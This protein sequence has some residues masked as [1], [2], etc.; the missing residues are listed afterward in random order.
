VTAKELVSLIRAKYK[1]ND[2]TYNPSVVLEQVPDG[3]GG[4]LNRWIDVAVFQMWASKGLTRAAFEVKISRA[5][6]INELRQPEK[7]KWCKECFHEFWFVAPKDVIQIEE[8]PANAG[9]MYPR[10]ARLCVARHAVRND[11]PRL[12]DHLLAAFMRA[13]NKEIIES[14]KIAVTETLASS[15]EYQKAIMFRKA[16]LVF[17]EKRNI[18]FFDPKTEKEIIDKLTEAT[19][20]KEFSQDRK[21]LME[22]AGKFQSDIADLALLFMVIANKSLLARDELGRHITNR[23][24]GNDVNS[25]EDL[26]ELAKSKSSAYEKRYFEVVETLLNWQKLTNGGQPKEG[27]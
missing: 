23:F 4:Y 12:D 20:D 21:L 13:A 10:G 27:G 8:L 2:T 26:K 6:F 16:T 17:L 5:D 22:M 3:T 24:G 25:L 9:W 1:T 14:S 7:H 15:E 11:N 19:S 18:N